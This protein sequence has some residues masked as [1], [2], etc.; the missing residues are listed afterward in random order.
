MASTNSTIYN[1][2]NMTH[3]DVR[4][5]FVGVDVMVVVASDLLEL[6]CSAVSSNFSKYC[7]ALFWVVV[8]IFLFSPLFG[9]DFQ[10]D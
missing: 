4:G 8:S 1:K 6:H 10:F 2:G 9:E 7:S 3:S 5:A